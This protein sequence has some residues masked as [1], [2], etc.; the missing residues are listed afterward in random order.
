M[1]KLLW[2][3][4]FSY[5]LLAV[6]TLGI[7]L[8]IASFLLKQ[9]HLDQACHQ[10]EA[11]ARLFRSSVEKNFALSAAE[12]NLLCAEFSAELGSRITVIVATGQVL[13][14]SE[15]NSAEMN[16]H[17]DRPEIIA[18]LAG[19]IGV[20]LRRSHSL[21]K[22]LLYVAVPVRKNGIVWGVVRAALPA[23]LL[24]E[25]LVF[26]SRLLL[27]ALPALLLAAVA[28]FLL[29]LRISRPLE[30]IEQGVL[31]F[32]QGSLHHRIHVAGPLEITSLSESCNRMAAQ[33]DEQTAVLKKQLGLLESTFRSM[34][35]A[36]IVIDKDGRLLRCNQAAG[37][38]FG[39][40]PAAVAQ[41][42]I[43]EIIRHADVQQFLERTLKNGGPTEEIIAVSI[44]PEKILN[45]HGC[46][47]RGEIGQDGGALLVFHD[48]TR[49]KQLETMRRD[50][51]A[52]VS[53][54]LKTP[55]T[56]I[57]GFVETLRDGAMHEPEDAARFLEII[58]RNVRRLHAIIEDLLAL[59]RLEQDE[60]QGQISL[61]WKAIKPVLE[62]AAAVC[63]QA[64]EE[65]GIS[66]E[67]TCQDALKAQINSALLEQA[68]VNLLNNAIK[69]SSAG[70]TVILQVVKVTS[71]GVVISVQDFGCGIG[72]EH[73]ARLFERFYRVDKARSCKLGGTGLGLAIAKHIVQA[74][75]GTIVVESTL[76][77]GSV[78]SI[79]LPL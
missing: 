1:K 33:L 62:N 32:T 23:K 13:A 38:L 79:R 20:S 34:A 18:A 75:H 27:A 49:L 11:Q 35:E 12:I 2:K 45:A 31:R 70:S 77:R 60:E 63:T 28:S 17:A 78:F 3:L 61:S 16:N 30:E 10:L 58:A 54:E 15:K 39:F 51:A 56:A 7:S 14:D 6:L 9:F 43:Q 40:D 66:V 69:Y 55:I 53:H 36:V 50:F 44:G 29:A 19:E 67:L 25:Q 22:E 47:L 46:L 71:D 41:R 72:K 48:I 59:A 74:H 68:V 37:R 5:L 73:H 76:G 24:D 64:A 65:K 26:H 57:S 42:D 4:C 21:D 52:N 8:I